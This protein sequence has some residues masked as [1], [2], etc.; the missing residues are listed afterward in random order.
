MRFSTRCL[1]KFKHYVEEHQAIAEVEVTSAQPLNATQ[2]EKMQLQWKEIS[3]Q[4]EIKL[5]R[6]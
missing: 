3:S 4:S 6:R 1:K 5:Q 2:I